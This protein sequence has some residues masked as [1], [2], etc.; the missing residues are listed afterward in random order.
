[1]SDLNYGAHLGNDRVLALF[2]EARVRWLATAG[3][4]EHDLGGVGLIQTEAQVSYRAQ[5]RLGD[6][7][8]CALVLTTRRSRGFTLTYQLTRPADGARIATGSTELRFFDYTLQRL[9]S[10][11]AAF[12]ARFPE[13][14]GSSAPKQGDRSP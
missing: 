1:V 10:A 3:W 7:L 11:P 14:G 2:H 8:E 5:G 9:A 12:L 6:E 4:S 13:V